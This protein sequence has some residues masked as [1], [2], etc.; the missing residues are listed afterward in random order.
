MGRKHPN[1]HPKA[2]L[3]STLGSR[4]VKLSFGHVMRSRVVGGPHPKTQ[5]A[6]APNSPERRPA[7]HFDWRLHC[8]VALFCRIAQAINERQE[9]RMTQ[10]QFFDA[11]RQDMRN[12]GQESHGRLAQA[13]GELT[14]SMQQQAMVA[15]QDTESARQAAL[16]GFQEASRQAQE[17]A[18]QMQGPCERPSSGDCAGAPLVFFAMLVGSCLVLGSFSCSC[19]CAR[20]DGVG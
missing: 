9:M 6:A 17:R 14:N 4:A 3:C 15:Q 16:S 1:P 18:D 2:A 12:S 11:L 10:Q 7:A 20:A 13:L 19:G 8:F 5:R